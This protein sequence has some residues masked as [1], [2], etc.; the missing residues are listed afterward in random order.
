MK[1]K[2]QICEGRG[3]VPEG[4]YETCEELDPSKVEQCRACFGMGYEYV[5]LPAPIYPMTVQPQYQPSPWD[6]TWVSMTND[7]KTFGWYEKDC[8]SPTVF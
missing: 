8:V 6:P 3:I 1:V 7:D 2:C 4:F 5:I